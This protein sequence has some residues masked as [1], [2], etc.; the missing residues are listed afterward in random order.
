MFLLPFCLPLHA[1]E[2]YV[3]GII[4]DMEGRGLLHGATVQLRDS[5]G[6]L[7]DE[8]TTEDS[9]KYALTLRLD[10]RYSLL[11]TSPD[12]LPRRLAIDTR[13]VDLSDEEKEGGWG[14][15]VDITLPDKRYV[16]PAELLDRP[17]GS[18]RW[19]QADS[20]FTWDMGGIDAMREQWSKALEQ[21]G[22]VAEQ[23]A[24]GM[25]M[26]VR[27]AT[28]TMKPGFLIGLL[29]LLVGWW[30]TRRWVQ[31]HVER[32]GHPRTVIMV[33]AIVVSAGLATLVAGAQLEHPGVLIAFAGGGMLAGSLLAYSFNAVPRNAL[34]EGDDLI[35]ADE[36][37]RSA[38][39]ASLVFF[40]AF[41]TCVLLI[42]TLSHAADKTLHTPAQV[43]ILLAIGLASF[44]VVRSA[45]LPA[46]RRWLAL[47]IDRLAVLLGIAA[48]VVP[49]ILCIAWYVDRNMADTAEAPAGAEV[50]HIQKKTK[51]R[52]G[53]S[54]YEVF[55]LVEGKRRSFMI[56]PE[57]RDSVTT[58]DAVVY[59]LSQGPSGMKHIR[60]GE[61]V[62]R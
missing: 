21:Q 28:K 9:G 22:L 11:F 49:G 13:H 27:T 35:P 59:T 16:L 46:L 38:Q 44:A 32:M 51:R 24:A 19:V 20:M 30:A 56:E 1:H 58:D 3:Y 53:I 36:A 55:V 61:I 42:T 29:A 26:D 17:F 8:H 6:M 5:T 10:Q 39:R 4:R 48:V 34:L 52:G 7:V 2:V 33:L 43:F 25:V 12:H 57:E 60:F 50:V 54:G 18:A 45:A 14:M 23:H 40:G 15:N 41:I 47:R 31:R 37:L 62:M